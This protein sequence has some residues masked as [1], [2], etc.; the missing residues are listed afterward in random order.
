MARN[1]LLEGAPLRPGAS[2]LAQIAGVPVLPCVILGTDR[3]YSKR[4]W[5]LPRWRDTPIWI[6]FGN[7]ISHFPELQKLHARERIES[8]LAAAFKNLYAELREKFR[9]T[10]DDLPHPPRERTNCRAGA[11]PAPPR[12]GNRSGCP[13]I[14]STRLQRLASGTID[15]LICGS[16]NL[17]HTR[18]RLNGRGREEMARYV[19]ECE[20]LTPKE[21]YA[22]P[23]EPNLAKTLVNGHATMAWNSPIRTHFAANNV[24]HAEFFQSRA[25]NPRAHGV[26]AAR[27][28]V[29][30]LRRP[31]PLRRALQRTWLE[32][33]FPSPP[34]SLFAGPARLLEW[35]TCDHLRSH[36]QCRRLAPG[37]NR[38]A[39][40][41]GCIEGTRLPRV[42]RARHQLRRLDRRVTDAGRERF[43]LCGVNVARS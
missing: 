7:P 31:S 1:S 27:A 10:T 30:Q 14:S 18:H 35:R 3:L 29:Y 11:S 42:R 39:P 22:A 24:A 37:R 28:H 16:L 20:G 26:A 9:L 34:L 25:R 40:V 36:S 33:L 12:T 4:Q 32:R 21:Y 23:Y 43:P 41:D 6:A 19:A 2:T 8:E 17:L 13:T 15:S 38:I 5:L